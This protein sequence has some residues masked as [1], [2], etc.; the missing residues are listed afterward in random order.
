MS[1][2]SLDGQAK[3]T[4]IPAP[5]TKGIDGSA[6]AL[7]EKSELIAQDLVERMGLPPEKL[8]S[9]TIEI[10]QSLQVHR[11]PLPQVED[12]EGYERI[13]PGAADRILTMAELQQQQAHKE[14]GNNQLFEFILKMFGQLVALSIIAGLLVFA[15]FA[16]IAGY[17]YLAALGF[18]STVIWTGVSAWLRNSSMAPPDKSVEP[19]PSA[20]P[21]ENSGKKNRRNRR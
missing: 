14:S 10:A 12:F 5:E 20:R 17:P 2:N 21:P 19:V 9:L 7:L 1:G 4:P 6:P 15:Y 16:M 8:Q 13:C 3:N 18:T 11:G